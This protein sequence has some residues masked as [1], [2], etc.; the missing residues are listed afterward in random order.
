MCYRYVAHLS[1]S[2][3]SI[4]RGERLEG[5]PCEGRACVRAEANTLA[6]AC[7]STY[8]LQQIVEHTKGYRAVSL[9]E[10]GVTPLH[11]FAQLKEMG[12]HLTLN[13]MSGIFAAAK[14]LENV[15]GALAE[16]GTTADHMDSLMPADR[17]RSVIG[18]APIREARHCT[19]TRGQ[20]PGRKVC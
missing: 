5:R 13:P 11:T 8:E 14:A 7:R 12:F 10:Q 19:A 1:V 4:S 18:C 20:R 6:P 15:Y 9:S 17:F 3:Q 2:E 16:T